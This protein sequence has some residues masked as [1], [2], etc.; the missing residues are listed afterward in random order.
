MLLR[1]SEP[2]SVQS[3]YG[4]GFEAAASERSAHQAGELR[5]W[6]P[7]VAAVVAVPIRAMQHMKCRIGYRLKISCHLVW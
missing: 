6:Y 1:P 7:S 4:V 2:G 5:V 3:P